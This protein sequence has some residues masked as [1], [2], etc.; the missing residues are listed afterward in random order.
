VGGELIVHCHVPVY[1]LIHV[2]S[3]NS[4]SPPTDRQLQL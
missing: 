1:M 3:R 2:L 4:P